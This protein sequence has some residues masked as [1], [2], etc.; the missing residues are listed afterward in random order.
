[1]ALLQ[2]QLTATVYASVYVS[3]FFLFSSF[4]LFAL[5]VGSVLITHVAKGLDGRGHDAKVKVLVVQGH[6]HLAQHADEEKEADEEAQGVEG[7]GWCRERR[8]LK[9]GP[10]TQGANHQQEHGWNGDN[11][12][13]FKARAKVQAFVPVRIQPPVLRRGR[14]PLTASVVQYQQWRP[15]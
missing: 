14:R 9:Q 6:A 7:G 5:R 13:V 11:N 15:T 12:C 4:G 10:K 2:K 1:M 3:C 8:P